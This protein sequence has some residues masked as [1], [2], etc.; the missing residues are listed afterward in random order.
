MLFQLIDLRHLN[1][2]F[3]I[4]AGLLVMKLSKEVALHFE[5]FIQVYFSLHKFGIVLHLLT[6]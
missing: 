3:G 1:F 4:L 6:L 2:L 5:L